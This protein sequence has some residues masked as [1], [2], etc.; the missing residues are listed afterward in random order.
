MEEKELCN[1]YL[2]YTFSVEEKKEMAANL[3]EK[4]L[5][6]QECEDEKKQ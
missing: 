2:K 1:E 3:A 5:K 4:V 6:L